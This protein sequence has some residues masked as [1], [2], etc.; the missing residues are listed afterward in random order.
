MG[1]SVATCLRKGAQQEYWEIME[2]VGSAMLDEP[3]TLDVEGCSLPLAAFSEYITNLMNHE[4]TI[5]EMPMICPTNPVFT[6][7]GLSQYSFPDLMALWR[8]KF[9]IATTDLRPSNP[10]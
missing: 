8:D 6:E 3:L 7:D 9:G 2:V 10:L 4:V 5:T 1:N